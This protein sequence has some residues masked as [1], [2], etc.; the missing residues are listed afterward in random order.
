MTKSPKNIYYEAKAFK[1]LVDDLALLRGKMD[2]YRPVLDCAFFVYHPDA[3]TTQWVITDSHIMSSY[4]TRPSD[5]S[6]LED[7]G[8]DV[9]SDIDGDPVLC[10]VPLDDLKTFSKTVKATSNDDVVLTFATHEALRLECGSSQARIR[11][12][13]GGQAPAMNTFLSSLRERVTEGVVKGDRV[14]HALN[15]KFL[16]AIGSCKSVKDSPVRCFDEKTTSKGDWALK[17][18]YFVIEG[19]GVEIA[20]VLM[21]IRVN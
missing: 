15:R 2:G 13:Q 10:C 3:G 8:F 6:P 18:V 1:N 16:K 12:L 7:L 17:P 20:S 5:M 21:P 4:T 11:L 9:G 14:P 19:E